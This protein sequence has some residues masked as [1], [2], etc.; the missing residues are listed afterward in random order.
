MSPDSDPTPEEL[1]QAEALARALDGAAP[2]TSTATSTST[3]TSTSTTTA[4]PPD[5]PELQTAAL[6]RESLRPPASLTAVEEKAWAQHVGAHRRRRG[7]VVGLSALAAG[8]VL[9]VGASALLQPRAAPPRGPLAP[10]SPDEALLR[11]QLAAARPGAPQ[12]AAEQAW[13]GY[14][15]RSYDA[16]LSRYGGGR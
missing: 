14:R 6:L 9:V 7:W 1:A 3:S 12:E 2:A 4:A 8:V 10:P 11:A 5:L 15:A 13:E 16:L